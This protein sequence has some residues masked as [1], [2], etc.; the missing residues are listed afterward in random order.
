MQYEHMH[1]DPNLENPTLSPQERHLSKGI[2]AH[3]YDDGDYRLKRFDPNTFTNDPD[4]WWDVNAD[5][6]LLE[7]VPNYIAM[8]YDLRQEP[9]EPM[10]VGCEV[11]WDEKLIYRQVL[12]PYTPVP[13]D[14]S[15]TVETQE[16]EIIA[17]PPEGWGKPSDGEMEAAEMQRNG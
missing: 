13:R 12:E 7:W 14:S 4:E 15:P 6:V 8:L 16:S 1:T 2:A 5:Q 11:Y 9:G 3:Y 10:M 17:V